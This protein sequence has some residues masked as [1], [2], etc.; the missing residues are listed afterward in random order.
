MIILLL[1]YFSVFLR[2]GCWDFTLLIFHLLFT[3]FRVFW[4]VTLWSFIFL[5]LAFLY[6]LR[7]FRRM[8]LCRF[9]ILMFAILLRHHH[10]LCLC[11]SISCS[12]CNLAV[13]ISYPCCPCKDISVT[14]DCR[15]SSR[16]G[17][18]CSC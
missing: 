13:G 5:M 1:S 4:R 9:I 10:F 3:H 14:H 7:V 17:L 15:A 8:A 12:G 11:S 18:F 6:A 16:D 2:T